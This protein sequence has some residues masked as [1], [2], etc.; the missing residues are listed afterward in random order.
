MVTGFSHALKFRP[1]LG[2][3][4]KRKTAH[5]LSLLSEKVSFLEGRGILCQLALALCLTMVGTT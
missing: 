4:G 2:C 5:L 1:Q 3:V